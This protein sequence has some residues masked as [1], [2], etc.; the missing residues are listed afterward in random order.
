MSNKK[1]EQQF[2]GGVMHD[3]NSPASK[4]VKPLIPLDAQKP[5]F[6]P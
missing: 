2:I 4:I 5:L 1:G 6:K 3:A